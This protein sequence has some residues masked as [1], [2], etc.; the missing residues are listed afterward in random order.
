MS[1]PTLPVGGLVENII[2]KKPK[3]NIIEVKIIALPASF[4]PDSALDFVMTEYPTFQRQASK[5]VVMHMKA[6]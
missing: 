3:N 1:I 6:V 4:N 2:L 5:I